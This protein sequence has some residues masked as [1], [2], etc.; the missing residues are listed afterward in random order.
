MALPVPV[1][2]TGCEAGDPDYAAPERLAVSLYKGQQVTSAGSDRRREICHMADTRSRSG[3]T[4][5]RF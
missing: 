3:T 1:G 4:T 5:D 2:V